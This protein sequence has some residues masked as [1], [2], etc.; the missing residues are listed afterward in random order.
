M[1]YAGRL[2]EGNKHCI[3]LRKVL[4]KSQAG[5][6]TMFFFF[7]IIQVTFLVWN[8]NVRLLFMFVPDKKSKAYRIFCAGGVSEQ[9]PN[10][11]IDNQDHAVMSFF[12]D[13]FAV[14]LSYT[15]VKVKLYMLMTYPI[16]DSNSLHARSSITVRKCCCY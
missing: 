11:P 2:E 12:R 3:T 6:F 4:P 13:H 5:Q 9:Y 10:N 15:P 14:Y 7:T 16:I 8:E 1:A